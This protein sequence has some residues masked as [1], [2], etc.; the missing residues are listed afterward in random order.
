MGKNHTSHHQNFAL[1]LG[2]VGGRRESHRQGE[3]L[4]SGAPGRGDWEFP[5]G[6]AQMD[7]NGGFF[8]QEQLGVRCWDKHMEI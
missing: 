3:Y 5:Q 7:S 4:G 2:R 1:R 6:M 8:N